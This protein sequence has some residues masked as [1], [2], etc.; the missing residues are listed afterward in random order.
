MCKLRCCVE[1]YIHTYVMY[2]R[3]VQ[4]L[5][6]PVIILMQQLKRKMSTFLRTESQRKSE[7]VEDWN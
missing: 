6:L 7:E 3:L 5:T 2:L 4:M 1:V